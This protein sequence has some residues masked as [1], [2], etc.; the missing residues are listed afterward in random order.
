M[1]P[2]DL[3]DLQSGRVHLWCTFYSHIENDGLLRDYRSLL[4]DA[5][6]EHE[7]HFHFARDQRRYLVT[8]A[9]VRTVLSRYAAIPPREW[10]FVP[11]D[12]G[13][14]RIAND[15][16]AARSL[17]FNIS[18]TDSL[19]ILAVAHG[20]EVGVDVENT[21]R[22]ASCI[23]IADRFFSTTEVRALRALPKEDQQQRFFEYWTLKESYIKARSLGLA[24]ALDQFSFALC[25]DTI[26]LSVHPDQ[27]DPPA[28]WRFWQMWL[29]SDYLGALCVER[30]GAAVP[31][32]RVREVVP[33]FS[34]QELG[35][36]LIRSS[37][38]LAGCQ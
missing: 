16:R 20:L 30:A 37:A 15:S 23:E 24:I 7:F 36:T 8:R 25:R 22:R 4:S 18:H 1:Y 34:Q 26:G 32:L 38:G 6:R 19:I 28:R 21:R 2:F 33:L 29:G 5:E 3:T 9:L 14:P 17:C 12:Y 27:N 10:V 35:F 31:R 11:N 13:R